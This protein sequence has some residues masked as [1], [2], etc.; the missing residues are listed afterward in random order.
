MNLG[1]NKLLAPV[2]DD[3][4]P[5][6]CVGMNYRTHAAEAGVS[7]L[8]IRITENSTAWDERG[9]HPHANSIHCA[10]PHSR[11][12]PVMDQASRGSCI[13][14]RRHSDEQILRL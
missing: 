11:K 6:Y 1:I 10:A 2:L 12:S 3:S 7:I 14:V 13:A 9:M 5:I 8:K 4:I